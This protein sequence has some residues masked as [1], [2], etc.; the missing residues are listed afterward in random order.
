MKKCW[1]MAPT[2]RPNFSALVQSLG[3]ILAAVAGYVELN[4]T[5]LTTEDEHQYE[6]VWLPGASG[7]YVGHN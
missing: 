6:E 2:D 1:K 5:L 4:M 7:T 3:K